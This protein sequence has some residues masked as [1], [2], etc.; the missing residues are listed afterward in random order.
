MTSA[1]WRKLSDVSCLVQP[2]P[3]E[4]RIQILIIHSIAN[5][6]FGSLLGAEPEPTILRE[7]GSSVAIATVTTYYNESVS[8]KKTCYCNSHYRLDV[9]C[10]AI[11]IDV[12]LAMPLFS[13]CR[14]V[15]LGCKAFQ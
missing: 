5:S 14:M 8:R 11:Y 15:Y 4:P 10:H 9:R 13:Q 12:L 2:S 1:N 6:W 7:S 3:D